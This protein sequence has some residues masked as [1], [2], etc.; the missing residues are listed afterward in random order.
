LA[1]FKSYLVG[2][3]WQLKPTKS[4]VDNGDPVYESEL[5]GE[6]FPHRFE[7]TKILRQEESEVKFKEALNMMAGATWQVR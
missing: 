2:D 1:G 6:V 7:L 3:F 4:V 5:F